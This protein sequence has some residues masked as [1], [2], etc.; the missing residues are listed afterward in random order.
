MKPSI[1]SEGVEKVEGKLYQK[2]FIKVPADYFSN[3]PYCSAI[4]EQG[5]GSQI[6]KCGNCKKEYYAEF[7]LPNILG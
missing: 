7:S 1:F 4:N 5:E 2:A 3:C 6:I